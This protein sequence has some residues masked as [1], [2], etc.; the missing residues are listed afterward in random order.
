MS[1]RY[2][3]RPH[4]KGRRG[5]QTADGPEG[6]V[7]GTTSKSTGTDGVLASEGGHDILTDELEDEPGTVESCPTTPYPSR[8]VHN[9]LPTQDS[10]EDWQR[11]TRYRVQGPAETSEEI[12]AAR[13]RVEAGRVAEASRIRR[14]Q[15]VRGYEEDLRA[16]RA[17]I[18]ALR[19]ECE[20]RVEKMRRKWVRDWAIERGEV[21]VVVEEE[22]EMGEEEEENMMKPYR[23]DADGDMAVDK[24]YAPMETSLTTDDDKDPRW[25][26]SSR[27]ASS[28]LSCSETD[29]P[30]SIQS[31]SLSLRPQQ[32]P[33]MRIFPLSDK[34]VG[35]SSRRPKPNNM[36]EDER[37][38]H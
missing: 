34:E 18:E 24:D 30:P 29:F 33:H 27:S 8:A 12:Q 14:E 37:G 11:A 3:L 38:H 25:Q 36:E 10:E 5:H 35:S 7:K 15:I 6:Q 2:S 1:H 31:S 23:E 20:V 26:W 13:K 17:R 4:A 32:P 22:E 9:T 16:L 28:H 21:V 19:R